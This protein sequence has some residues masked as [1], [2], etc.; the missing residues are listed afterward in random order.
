MV[1]DESGRE[2]DIPP[3]RIRWNIAKEDGQLVISSPQGNYQMVEIRPHAPGDYF[4]AT[5]YSPTGQTLIPI[6]H[7][8]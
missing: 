5:V 7:K 4:I 2:A 6:Y 8:E 1:E 3:R